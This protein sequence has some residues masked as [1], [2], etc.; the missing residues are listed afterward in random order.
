MNL[1]LWTFRCK[2]LCGHVF[3]SLRSETAA[4]YGN[5]MFNTELNI[6]KQLAFQTSCTT[7]HAHQWHMNLQISLHSCHICHCLLDY[8]HSVGVKWYFIVALIFISMLVN[9]GKHHFMC[10]LPI[11]VYVCVYI[12]IYIFFFFWEF[13]IPFAHFLRFKNLW[14]YVNVY[15][16]F[17]FPL[18]W[19]SVT[20]IVLCC[21]LALIRYQL[22]YCL[23][24]Y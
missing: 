10:L 17:K 5:S 4:S 22:Y 19:I 15:W 16:S 9:N 24:P 21:S 6:G 8:S 18:L 1:L 12:Y 3:I 14:E 20:C 13:Y 2:F 7:L 11:C 23:F